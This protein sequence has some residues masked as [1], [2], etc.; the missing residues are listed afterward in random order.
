M[1]LSCA[2]APRPDLPELAVLAEELGYTRLWVYDSPA[3][4][5]DCWMSLARCADVTSTIGLG[6]AVLVPSLRHPMVNASAI[7]TL[8]Q[9]AP[10]RAAA[11]LGTGLTGRFV[12]GQ[13]P[14]TW[15]ATE[16]Y[17]RQL[18]GL[19]GGDT[20]EIDGAPTRMIHPDGYVADRP[21][22][23]PILVGAN[24]PKGLDVAQ[25]VGADGVVSIFGAQPG[26]EWCALFA[27]GTLLDD[28]EDLGAERVLDAAGPGAAVVFHGMYEA[29]PALLDAFE[30]GPEWRDAVERFDERERHLFTHEEHFVGMTER[31]R[32]SVTPELIGST[33]WTG[34][35]EQL[36][37]RLDDTSAS[38]ISEFMYAPM[39]SDPIRELEAFR[40]L[41]P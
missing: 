4:F 31:D 19:L 10:G 18:I 7:A 32:A 21:I 2:F 39:G 15:A 35:A 3:L 1:E 29:D 26:W 9:L 17:L 6:P 13:K 23:T 8:E 5:G 27:Y 14:M 34:T 25:H 12:M 22:T 16:T 24:G 11:A 28:G 30:G 20:V 38:G 37:Q 40:T 33:T 41:F 36:R